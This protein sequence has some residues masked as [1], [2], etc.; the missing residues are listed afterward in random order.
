LIGRTSVEQLDL[1]LRANRSGIPARPLS[2]HVPSEWIVGETL[3][4]GAVRTQSR[5]RRSSRAEPAP[6]ARAR[7]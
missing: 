4:A 1:L 3:P 7:G 5:G 6:A 2:V